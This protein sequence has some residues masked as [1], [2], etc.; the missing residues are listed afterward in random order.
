MFWM[1]EAD[2]ISLHYFSDN[3]LSG[4]INI[5]LNMETVEDRAVIS[6]WL[7]KPPKSMK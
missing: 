6:Y 1:G 2:I 5:C 4:K 3:R 7:L